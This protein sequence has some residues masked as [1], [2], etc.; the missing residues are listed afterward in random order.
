MKFF[1]VGILTLT[2]I[3]AFA[4]HG[5]CKVHLEPKISRY[6]AP[7]PGQPT[8]LPEAQGYSYAEFE[9][10]ADLRATIVHSSKE[11]VNL[12][13]LRGS[14]RRD[15]VHLILK[16]SENNVVTKKK[17]SS[18]YLSADDLTFYSGC[19]LSNPTYARL[20][21]KKIGSIVKKLNC[22]SPL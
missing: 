19:G 9:D 16:D 13:G 1:L 7:S 12:L 15:N 11:N 6:F 4:E 3:S 17:L 10:Q 2:S 5:E 22:V 21:L 14:G 8:P 20:A 18:C